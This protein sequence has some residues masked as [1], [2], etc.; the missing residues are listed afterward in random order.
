MAQTL[1]FLFLW[2]QLQSRFHFIPGYSTNT[3][4]IDKFHCF[5]T[6][7][8]Y[9]CT[10]ST[11]GMCIDIFRLYIMQRKRI[12]SIY[13]NALYQSVGLHLV[14]SRSYTVFQNKINFSTPQV[15]IGNLWKTSSVE[16]K[17]IFF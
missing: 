11:I 17:T 8:Q 2:K 4:C 6:L 13:Q 9:F 1:T 15:A 3:V 10:R 14:D 5:R 16:H 12:G 7:H